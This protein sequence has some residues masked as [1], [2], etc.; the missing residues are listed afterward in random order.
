MSN[1]LPVAYI[2]EDDYEILSVLGQGGFGITYL[3]RDVNLDFRVVIKE[4]LPRDM[5]ARDSSSLEVRPFTKDLD[6]YE[7]L[8]GRFSEEA[9]L[10]A[11]M[12]HP[13]VVRVIRFFKANNTAY[14]VMEY[15]EGETLKDYLKRNPTLK[16]EE[17]LSIMIPILEGS[18]YVHSLGF[19][20]RDIAPDNIYLCKEG[21]P[22]LIDFGA[23]RDAIAQQSK[24]ISSI[25]KEGY[26]S[27]EQYTVNN[28]QDASSDIYALGAVFYRLITGR[29]P[30]NAPHRQTALLNEEA[31][32]I[33]DISREYKGKYSQK[34]LHA[35]K[36]AMNLRAKDRFSSVAEFQQ[37][38]LDDI[39]VDSEPTISAQYKAAPRIEKK[40]SKVHSV[41]S[42]LLLVL[43]V[44]AAGIFVYL[45]IG[46]KP[47]STH[48]S[49]KTTQE[50]KNISENSSENSVRVRE[51]AERA[52]KEER[53]QARREM[54]ELERERKAAELE[55]LKREREEIE[56]L[57][58]KKKAEV[59]RMR[60]EAE[61][62]QKRRK[63]AMDAEKRRREEEAKRVAAQA[64]MEEKDKRVTFRENGISIYLSYPASV[65]AGE[66]FRITASM[67]NY[68]S[69]AKQGGLTL[70]FPDIES[71]PGRV[72]YSNFP[73]INGYSYPQR[74]YNRNLHRAIPAK[75]FMVEGWS[76]RV[77]RYGEGKNFTIELKAPYNLYEL[78]VNLRGILWIRG[79]HDTRKIPSYSDIYDQQGFPVKQFAIK[80]R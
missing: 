70:S 53:E 27:P 3:A 67:T 60:R 13:N 10:L 66:K 22:M 4:F 56:R 9:Q 78:K 50:R 73:K 16:E 62:A 2:L 7:H 64:S 51:S 54:K 49:V 11:R 63:E 8:L 24:N 42:I 45:N 6:N 1:A 18:K 19:L 38:L 39:V 30:V 31:D 80:I 35:V 36:K 58:E 5:A 28:R 32:P 26:S 52:A 47:S 21:M 33:G 74:I 65:V 41:V 43:V 68:N 34:L 23:A 17:I 55:K 48:R 59:E 75:Y 12:N 15:S 57:K 37:V 29:V 40:E 20:H 25:V 14:F 72:I 77:W 79:K 71:L 46:E 61:E 76:D 69:R 44:I